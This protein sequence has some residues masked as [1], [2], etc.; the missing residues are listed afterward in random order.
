MSAAE[1]QSGY[2]S[3]SSKQL[4]KRLHSAYS[5]PPRRRCDGPPQS[6][7]R[8]QLHLPLKEG[9]F[10]LKAAGDSS[11][12]AP[13]A[14]NIDFSLTMASLTSSYLSS[15]ARCYEALAASPT[16][17]RPLSQL[18]YTGEVLFHTPI[19]SATRLA[20]LWRQLAI[21]MREFDEPSN[22][23]TQHLSLIHI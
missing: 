11:H 22:S 17:L 2:H 16:C 23:T 5:K 10:Y 19:P 3:P 21:D 18:Q 14:R 6:L 12:H 9:A 13:S 15:A 1:T 8:Q 20:S 7:F 4:W